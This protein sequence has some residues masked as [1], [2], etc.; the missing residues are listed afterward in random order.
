MRD[1]LVALTAVGSL[2]GG[3]RVPAQVPDRANVSGEVA[4]DGEAT[5][6]DFTG[7][8]TALSGRID[9]AS[10]IAGVRGWVEFPVRS[11]ASGNGKRDRDMYKSLEVDAHP[12]IRFDL[13]GVGVGMADGDSTPVTLRGAFT[14][15]GVSLERPVSG[16]IWQGPRGNVQFRGRTPLNLRDFG[17]GGLSKMLGL[18]KM[19]ETVIV[20]VDLTFSR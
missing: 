3:A 10:S 1:V 13:M 5:L 2:A 17:I 20:R 14:I 6:G 16:W 7:R 15:R 11:L 19:G 8:S 18:L 9:G 4:F 12:T